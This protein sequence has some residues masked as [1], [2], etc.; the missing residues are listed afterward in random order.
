[1]IHVTTGGYTLSIAEAWPERDEPGCAH[2]VL[3]ERI[4]TA[5][6]AVGD[7]Y[8]SDV[9]L[10][11]RAA[12]EWPTWPLLCVAQHYSPSS[13]AG[14]YPGFLLVPETAILFIGAGERIVAYDLHGPVRR[15]EDHTDAGF[16]DWQRHGELV[17]MSAELELAA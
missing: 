11:V 9:H 12:T 14:C 8:G 17:V 10:E 3:V 13:A 4:A 7:A 2:A 1:M 5:M 15:W 16:H 6:A